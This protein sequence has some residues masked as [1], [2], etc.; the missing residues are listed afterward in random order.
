MLGIAIYPAAGILEEGDEAF[1]GRVPDLNHIDLLVLPFV[2]T[3]A[4][5]LLVLRALVLIPEDI[6]HIV[7]YEIEVGLGLVLR[8]YKQQIGE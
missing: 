1:P 5:F 6:S 3:V 2:K 8:H 7:E 4:N